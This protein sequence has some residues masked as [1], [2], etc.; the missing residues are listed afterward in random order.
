[1]QLLAFLD[2]VIKDDWAFALL[3]DAISDWPN[4]KDQPSIKLSKLKIT[5]TDSSSLFHRNLNEEEQGEYE[6]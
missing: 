1:M 3:E 5:E 6:M 2:R 4:D